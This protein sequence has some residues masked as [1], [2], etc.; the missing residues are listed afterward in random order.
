MATANPTKQQPSTAPTSK[1]TPTGATKGGARP[2]KEA[3][4]S[5]V[6]VKIIRTTSDKTKKSTPIEDDPANDT[7]SRENGDAPSTN[8]AVVTTEETGT[9]NEQED[10]TPVQRSRF[11]TLSKIVRTGLKK[12]NQLSLEVAMALREIRDEELYL[13]THKN[14]K[15]YCF[16]E[17]HLFKSHAYAMA[18]AGAVQRDLESAMADK[19]TLPKNERQLR[20][21]TKLKTREDR[22]QAWQRALELAGD[23]PVTEADARKAVKLLQ[24]PAKSKR[25]FTP[26]RK[27]TSEWQESLVT[28]FTAHGYENVF[29]QPFK[30]SSDIA[31]LYS[32][33]RQQYV[34]FIDTLNFGESAVALA[35]RQHAENSLIIISADANAPGG[36][37]F[38]KGNAPDI[39]KESFPPAFH[40]MAKQLNAVVAYEGMLYR[41]GELGES[42]QTAWT[43]IAYAD[44]ELPDRDDEPEDDA[45]EE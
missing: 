33:E 42:F 21:L 17:F 38:S 23:K 41:A 29:E 20:P 32:G 28:K 27:L 44:L 37:L 4:K 25:L 39:E 18:N 31:N 15:E 35:L 30:W 16:S 22:V 36:L 9:A 43:P 8:T 13:G 6:P 1:S 40:F 19:S 24:P 12:M 2:S 3:P 45:N 11:V 26:N 5:V 7:A 14:F 10:L 34:K